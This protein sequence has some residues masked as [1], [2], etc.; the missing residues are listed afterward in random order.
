MMNINLLPWRM[1][2]RARARRIKK[3][4]WIGLWV[5]VLLIMLFN[6]NIFH[7][8]KPPQLQQKNQKKIIKPAIISL[9]TVSLKQLKFIG[10]IQQNNI[11]WALISLP[12]GVTQ[13]V[14][15]G[16]IIGKEHARVLNISEQGI[17]LGVRFISRK[18]YVKSS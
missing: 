15:I 16:D 8:A 18:N 10:F 7:L 17:D 11:I 3:I 12:N 14:V 6:K 9:Q 13:V 2:Q 4:G 5:C 1:Y